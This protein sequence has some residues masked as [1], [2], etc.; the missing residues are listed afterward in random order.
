MARPRVSEL[1]RLESILANLARIVPD[2]PHELALLTRLS[3][4][5]EKRAAEAVNEALRPLELTYVLYNA[6]MIIHAGDGGSAP[7]DIAELTGE[8]PSNVTHICNH[9]QGLGLITRAPARDDRRRIVI[10]LSAAGRRVLARAQP[11]VWELWRRRFQDSSAQQLSVLPQLLR[12]Q[13]HNLSASAG[14][15]P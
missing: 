5:L 6:L 7:S 8:R 1:E 13:I 15:A 10:R 11:L 3:A 4:L 9:L 2:Y 12:S 14:G